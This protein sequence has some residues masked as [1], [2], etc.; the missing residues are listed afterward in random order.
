MSLVL[1][2]MLATLFPVPV[3]TRYLAIL[4]K[5][6]E[7]DVDLLLRLL[8]EAGLPAPDEGLQ[9]LELGCGF[10]LRGVAL[11]RAGAGV[12]A[13]DQHEPSLQLARKLA[14]GEGGLPIA[15]RLVHS[16]LRLVPDVHA[17]DRWFHLGLFFGGVLNE[18]GSEE[19]IRAVLVQMTR[20]LN[21]SGG[22][23]VI[24]GPNPTEVIRSL[25]EPFEDRTVNVEPPR[26]HARV[27]VTFDR[28]EGLLVSDW[29]T[30][31]GAGPQVHQI[32]TRLLELRGLIRLA[33]ECGLR[34][35]QAY[36]DA[37]G[38]ALGL[39]SPR[40]IAVFERNVHM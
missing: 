27:H 2:T 12:V 4:R 24:S 25:R 3:L 11:A 18:V 7:A 5:E 29:T 32:R 9:V 17:P 37:D 6:I 28:Q 40:L 15:L 39:D 23:L 33:Q 35:V 19:Q 22:R 10:G 13:V 14:T 34:F 36:G 1:P 31:N 38:S 16:D 30:H 20:R 21:P 8:T 26:F